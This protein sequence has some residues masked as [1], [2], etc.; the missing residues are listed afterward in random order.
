[1]YTLIKYMFFLFFFFS[2][3]CPPGCKDITGDVSGNMVDGYR[4][5]SNQGLKQGGD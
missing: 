5:V 1:M 4:D 3:F 2:K